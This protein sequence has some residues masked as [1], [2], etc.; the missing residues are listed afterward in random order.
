MIS[1]KHKL[2]ESCGRQPT[3]IINNHSTYYK[4]HESCQDIHLIQQFFVHPDPKRHYEIQVCLQ[5]NLSNSLLKSI[6][7]LNERIY[8]PEELGI[9]DEDS[10]RITQIVIGKRL[11]FSDVYAY[12][13]EHRLEGYIVT[14]N[15]DIFFDK[16]IQN[17]RFTSLAHFPSVQALLRYE[18]SKS[19]PE[20]KLDM[21]KLNGPRIDSQDTWVIHSNF[22][23]NI[24][25]NI[26][27]F[28]FYFGMPGCD[29]SIIYHFDQAGLMVFNQCSTIRTYHYHESRVR[30]YTEKERIPP[31]YGCVIPS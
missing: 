7:L 31:P 26:C 5:Q 13:N 4:P 1:N 18:Y 12:C 2:W 25:D 3:Y 6:T 27:R 21:C 24:F 11:M 16:S 14:S 15:S 28:E 10:T 8:T 30:N 19:I 29:N 9:S 20:D 22:L 23:K 17:L